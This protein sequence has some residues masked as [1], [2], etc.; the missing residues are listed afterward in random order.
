MIKETLTKIEERLQKAETITA[1]NKSELLGLVSTL[2]TE[3]SELHQTHN[4][5]AESIAGFAEVSTREATRQGK[6]PELVKLSIEGL[7]ASAQ[8]FES[9]HPKLVGIV[10]SICSMLSN[11]G[12]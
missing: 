4:E 11:L 3:I 1:E 6:N 12:I 2:K 9:T 5:Q 10:N 7:A 8:E